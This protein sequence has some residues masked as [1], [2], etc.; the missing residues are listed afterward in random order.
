MGYSK[1]KASKTGHQHIIQNV[2][3]QEFLSKCE[4]IGYDDI[5]D[6]EYENK[7]TLLQDINDKISVDIKWIVT[8]DGGYQEVNI[9]KNF[10][11]HALFL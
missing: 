8:A 3:V 6:L 5:P 9:N 2:L 10:P 11:S 4:K 7:T 1:E